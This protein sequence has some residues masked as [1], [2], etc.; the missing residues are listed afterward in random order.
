[1][2]DFFLLYRIKCHYKSRG[3]FSENVVLWEEFTVIQRLYIYIYIYIER[4]R[5]RDGQTDR[6][7]QRER[8]RE[9]GRERERERERGRDG[10]KCEIY[11]YKL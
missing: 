8:E 4:E 6:D 9:R 1:M 5:E 3:L 10:W 2:F 11:G 7:G